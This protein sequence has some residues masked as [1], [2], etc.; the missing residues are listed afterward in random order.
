MAQSAL[1]YLIGNKLLTEN[2]I[3]I[4]RWLIILLK[5]KNIYTE[6]VLSIGTY[7][8]FS[9]NILNFS[10]LGYQSIYSNILT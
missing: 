5:C 10:L 4:S 6:N 8:N 2:K 1:D 9:Q 7:N 3:Q